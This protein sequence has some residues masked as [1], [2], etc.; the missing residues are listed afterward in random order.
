MKRF[1]CL[2]IPFI[3]LLLLFSCGTPE[4]GNSAEAS[5]DTSLIFSETSSEAPVSLEEGSESYSEVESEEAPYENSAEESGVSVDEPSAPDLPDVYF[6]L[7]IGKKYHVTTPAYRTDGFGDY[8]ENDASALRYK[9]T[10]GIAAD[11]GSSQS[12]AGYD[13]QNIVIMLDLGAVCELKR[14]SVDV[15]GGK[16]GI[17]TPDKVAVSFS[18]LNKTQSFVSLGD[19]SPSYGNA[20]ITSRDE[21]YYSIFS[22]DASGVSARFVRLEI[23]SPDFIWLSELTV[24]GVPSEE[25]A[26][27]YKRVFI[28]TL[29]NDRVHR[30]SYHQCTVTAYDPTGAFEIISDTNAQIKIRGNSTSSGEKQP[31]NIKFEK[32]QDLF[33]FGKSKKWYLL[34]NMYDKTQLRNKL[35]FDLAD[36]IGMAYVQNSTFVELFLN[37]E[38]RGVYQ[39]CESIGIG[40]SR[41]DID[42]TGN[43]F[44]L[45]F[46]PWPQYSNEEWFTTPHYGIVLGFNDPDVPTEEQ[47]AYL[48]DFFTKA[49]NAIS[50]GDFEEICKYIDVQSFVDAFIVQ[51]FFK[52]VDYATSST[53]FYIKDGKLYEGPVWDFDLSS[54]NC[55]SEYYKGYNNVTTSGLSWQGDYCYGIW[56]GRLFR[57][58]EFLELFKARYKELQPYIVNVYAD[59]E[60]GKNRIDA[61]LEEFGD[62]ISLN[63]TIWSTSAVYSIL[64][65]VPEDGTYQSEIDYLRDWLEKRN[66]WLLERYGIE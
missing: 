18:V 20:E 55:S 25:S 56:N 26:V 2:I 51:E 7:A 34:A 23:T 64:E 28:E 1:I 8:D 57:C 41:V 45:E 19:V 30:S 12:I 58:K 36:D 37:G 15:Y 5:S 46:E 17:S 6:N 24:M 49:E 60:L 29:D 61:L 39:L 40:E 62:A 38:Y 4:P 3:L 54:G 65:K 22:V 44:L 59:N 9:L 48:Q 53:R 10:D 27:G 50:G 43:E 52:Q 21:W 42:V 33:G 63:Y 32:K 35:A 13:A 16:W 31:Y 14:I 11:S 66:A 47:R